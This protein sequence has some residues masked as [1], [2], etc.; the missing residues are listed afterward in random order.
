MNTPKKE[1]IDLLKTLIQIPS[2]SREESKSADAIESFLIK[3]GVAVNRE[4]NNIWAFNR[5]YCN[6]KKS[7][8]LNSHHDT[9]PPNGG[10]TMNPYS[11]VVD[12]DKLFGLGSNDA[13]ASVVALIAVF[14]NFYSQKDLPY[15]LCI[16]IS[17]EEE[18][19]GKNGIESILPK[20]GD[21]YFG[22]VAEPTEMK[23]A[24]AERGLM[25]LDCVVDGISS[26][27]ANS[28]GINPIHLALKDLQW[29]SSYK[30]DKVSDVLSEVKMSVTIINSG[31]KHNVIPSKCSF[32]VD[33]RS[34][35]LYSNDE[36]LDIVK[37]NVS[38]SVTARSTRLSSSFI[39]TNHP[40]VLLAQSM[41][42]ETFGSKTLSDQAL[43][44]F[45]TI[46]FGVGNSLRSHSAD[47][48]VLISEIE[49]G[50]DLY[51]DIFNNFFKC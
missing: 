46:K 26:H 2:I 35:E 12:G 43:M 4:N 7:I 49:S 19:S 40:F 14:L 30:F 8:L 13:G 15:N 9:V 48:Y 18:I 41:G 5:Y 21:I 39:D 45:D 36:I 23:M 6:T 29:F 1:V 44:K 34:N 50:I 28:N 32:T 31:E 33:I 16:A 47:E 10:Y 38:C 51:I 25:V 20:L 24:V 42:I 37:E 27:A 3:K 11:A 22:V 17:A